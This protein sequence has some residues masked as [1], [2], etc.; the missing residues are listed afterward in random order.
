MT[1]SQSV[2]TLYTAAQSAHITGPIAWTAAEGGL[3]WV[4]CQ[5]STAPSLIVAA[6]ERRAEL[7]SE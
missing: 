1:N 3:P 2:Y 6:L 7:R 5:F 4:C